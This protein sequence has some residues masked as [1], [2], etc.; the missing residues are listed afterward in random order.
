[1][2][3]LDITSTSGATPNVAPAAEPAANGA[4]DPAEYATNGSATLVTNTD[5][6]DAGDSRNGQVHLLG[7][8]ATPPGLEATADEFGFWVPEGVPVETTQLVRAAASFPSVGPV[9][10]YGVVEA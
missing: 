9:Q 10:F 2:N 1:M 4:I 3:E 5:R 7:R 6:D 8:V